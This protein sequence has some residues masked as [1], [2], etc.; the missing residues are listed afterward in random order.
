MEF[1][2]A[3]MKMQSHRTGLRNRK[4]WIWNLSDLQ[5]EA[6]LMIQFDAQEKNL[7]RTMHFRSV[8]IEVTFEAMKMTEIME[9]NID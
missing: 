3:Y 5:M 9:G 6:K 8:T 4:S 7:G 2:S 1:P